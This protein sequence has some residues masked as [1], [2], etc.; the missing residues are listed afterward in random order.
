M[1]AETAS[2]SPRFPPLEDLEIEEAVVGVGYLGRTQ[3]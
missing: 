1:A 3:K 2:R